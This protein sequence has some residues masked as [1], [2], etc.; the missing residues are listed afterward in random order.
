MRTWEKEYNGTFY[1]STGTNHSKGILIGISN[2]FDLPTDVE[3]IYADNEGRILGVKLSVNDVNYNLWNVYAPNDVSDRKLFLEHVR[4]IIDNYSVEGH[5]ILGGDFNTVL[6]PLLDKIGGNIPNPVCSNIINTMLDDYELTDIWR[7]RNGEEKRFTWKQTSPIMCTLDYWFIPNAIEHTVKNIDII[8]APRSDHLAVFLT[9]CHND[10]VKGNGYW[11][12]NN[13]WLQNA[14]YNHGI[15]NLIDECVVEYGDVLSPKHFWDLCKT[16][17]RCFTT[18]FAKGSQKQRKSELKQIECKLQKLYEKCINET[19]NDNLKVQYNACK[20]EYEV[21][22]SHFMKG[23]QIRSK[24]KWIEEGEKCTK[25]FLNLEKKNASKKSINKL[26]CNNGNMTTDQSVILNEEVAYF[27]DLFKSKVEVSETELDNFFHDTVF[28]TLTDEQSESCEGILTTEECLGALNY[29]AKNKSPGYDGLTVEFYQHFWSKIGPIVVNALNDAYL[30]GSLTT[31]QNRGIISLIHK[32]KGLP[33]DSLDNWRPIALLNIDYKIATKALAA[34]IKNILQFV[35]NSDQNGF[36]KGRSIHENIRL[37]E[38]VLRYVD[39]N[40]LPGVMMCIDFKKAFDSIERNFIFYALKKLN[41]G[42][43]FRKWISVIFR[44]TTN[45]IINNGHISSSFLVNCG[46]RQGC[47]ISPLIFVASVELLACKIRQSKQIQGIPLPFENYDRKEIRISTF[48]DDTTI[49]V[50]NPN[51]VKTVIDMFDNFAR[52]SGLSVNHAKS[53]AIWIG[54]LKNNNF[55]IGNVNW[56][57]GPNNTVKI[58]GVYFSPSISIDLLP[59]NWEDKMIKIECSIRAWKMRGLSM[60]GRNLIVKTLLASQLSYI[61]PVLNFPERVVKKLNT[62][63]FNFI[64]NRVEAVKRNTVIADYERGGMNIFHVELFFNS[65]KMSW[66]KKLNNSSVACWKNIPLYYVNKLGMGIN[67]FNCN[68]SFNQINTACKKVIDTLPGFYNNMFKVWFNTKCTS[69]KADI[70]DYYKQIVWNND[71]VT[72]NRK[73]LFYRDWIEAGFIFIYDLFDDDGLIY[74]F[75]YFRR[76]IKRTGS[77]LFQYFAL[78]NALPSE[79]KKAQTQF[80]QIEYG[81]IFNSVPIE[82]CSSKMFRHAM[83]NKRYV[84][85]V[86]MNYWSRRFPNYNFNWENIWGSIPRCTKEARLISLNWKIIHNI[87]PTKVLLCKMGKEDTNLCNDCNVVDHPEHFFFHC[88]K[89]MPIWNLANR[90]ITQKLEKHFSLSVENVLF[91]YHNEINSACSKYINYVIC[92]GK[93]CIGKFRYGGHPCLLFLFRQE[94]RMR[95][96]IGDQFS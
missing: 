27:S 1:S 42:A 30:S 22:Y 56:K 78:C 37:I 68:C 52:L 9:I 6:N 15:K 23:L 90:I 59:C 18:E 51:C 17:I 92:V 60:V 13:T 11:K 25:Y 32:G 3:K 21:M 2:K 86:C 64:W 89:T 94:L 35:V 57:L 77:V 73:T 53:D 39:K 82:A 91:N 76:R 5:T 20:L 48:A 95:G 74:S 19:D 80:D 69:N 66:I 87:Y 34:R 83:V 8:S 85:P 65:L 47:P 96:L 10:I 88:I 54:S 43:M 38:D 31:C 50:K 81:I 28:P 4:N 36:V 72:I 79:W 58:L 67:V 14:D 93:M 84:P 71:V 40:N 46:V 16:K 55:S 33:R 12:L 62:L 45:C 49:F 70:A 29:M 7:L 26:Q 63:F 61:A 44:N 75:E 24:E 41:F